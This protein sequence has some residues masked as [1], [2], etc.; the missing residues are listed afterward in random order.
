MDWHIYNG[1]LYCDVCVTEDE[2]RESDSYLAGALPPAE[3][4]V[5]CGLTVREGAR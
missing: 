1:D 5:S 4:C 2:A 3:E